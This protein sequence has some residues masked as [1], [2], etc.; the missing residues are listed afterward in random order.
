MVRSVRRMTDTD[1][2]TGI[3]PFR[4]DVPQADL[5]DLADRLARTRWAAELPGT[6]WDRGMPTADLRELAGYWA[7]AY[8]WRKAEAELDELPQFTTTIDGT[9]VHFLHVRSP[10]E[11]ALPL[12]LTHGWPGSIVEFLDVVDPLSDPRGHGGDP[13][14]AFHLVIPSIPGFGF[15][16]PWPTPGGPPTRVAA[17]GPSS[18][19]A[20]AT[21]GSAPRAA[22]SAPS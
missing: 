7:T 6:P 11:G 17:P 14:D 10:E 15:S 22:T 18:W 20:S 5:D 3:Q 19:P 4:I 13:A 8:D 16:G 2:G 9:R 12:V 21:T 1:T